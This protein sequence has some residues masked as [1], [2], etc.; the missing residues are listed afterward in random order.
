MTPSQSSAHPSIIA[1]HRIRP[2]SVE[3]T[4][5]YARNM[6]VPEVGVVGQQRIRAARVLVVGAGGLGCP[7]IAYLAAAGVGRL[8]IVDPDVVEISNLHRQVLHRSCDAGTA[9]TE[10][11]RRAVADLNPEV[12]V[13]TMPVRLTSA[14]A[15]E[16]LDGWDAV[17]DGTDN[18]PARYLLGDACLLA[19]IPLIH[20]AVLRSHG[21]VGVFDARRGPCYRCLH[22]AP[23]A[24]RAVPSCAQAGVLGV[25]PGLVGTMQATEA[26]KLIVGGASPLVGRLIVLD[27]WGARVRELPVR[28]NP[29]C[30][31]C[32]Q[33]GL[34]GLI[35]YEDFCGASGEE[36]GRAPEETGRARPDVP[37]IS[38]AELREWMRPEGGAAVTI[39][40]VR[41]EIEVAVEPMPGA[42]HIP[43]E[44]VVPR[45]DELDPRLPTIVVCAAG[46]RSA[47]AIRALLQAGYGGELINLD[48]GMRAWRHPQ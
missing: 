29:R 3:E 4:D 39:L 15:M 45:R 38:P 28:K 31:A 18:F 17:I 35:D 24:P 48:G 30:T 44:Q 42:V 1:D 9:K 23:P 6:L 2:L 22:P 20:G 11:A 7:A 37:G 10:S 13:I 41:E 40:D 16:A 34:T 27:A 43:L 47:R 46:A 26:L 12:E 33:Q 21:Q 5:R 8:G 14:N 25:L 32:G 19:G 36:T